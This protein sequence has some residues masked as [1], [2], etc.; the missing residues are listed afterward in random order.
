ME[1]EENQTFNGRQLG[2]FCGIID[3]KRE[4]EFVQFVSVCKMQCNT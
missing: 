4:S 2:N 1:I 3:R